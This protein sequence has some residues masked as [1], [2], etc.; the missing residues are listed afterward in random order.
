MPVSTL[1]DNLQDWTDIDLA[2]YQLALGMGLMIPDVAFA[3]R[4]K[5]IFWSENAIG[6]MLNDIL[7][8]FAENGILEYRDEPDYQYRWNPTFKGTWE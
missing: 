3:G 1:R 2:A 5:H 7:R 4:A 6:A 8:S